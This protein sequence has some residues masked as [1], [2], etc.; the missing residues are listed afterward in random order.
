M[1]GSAKSSADRRVKITPEILE[2]MLVMTAQGIST[3]DIAATFGVSQKAVRDRFRQSSDPRARVLAPPV[4]RGPDRRCICNRVAST[5]V[6][7]F[8]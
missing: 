7:H 6:S 3:R 4:P 8:S 5:S 1:G 2:K